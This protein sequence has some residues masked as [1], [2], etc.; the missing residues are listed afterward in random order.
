M[1]A[2]K[3]KP[4]KV[5]HVEDVI[6][7]DWWD[8]RHR[9]R[10]AVVHIAVGRALPHPSGGAWYCPVLVEG[11]PGLSGYWRPIAGVGPVDSTSNAFQ[12]ISILFEGLEA[13]PRGG[14][15]PRGKRRIR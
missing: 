7:E 9:G 10:P 3:W 5:T 11:F 12:L 1:A 14:T 8:I 6:A 4:V 15:P 13:S 2:K